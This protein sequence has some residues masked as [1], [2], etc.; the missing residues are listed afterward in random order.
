VRVFDG[1]DNK[2]NKTRERGVECEWNR[3]TD[4]NEKERSCTG[5]QRRRRRKSKRVVVFVLSHR[6]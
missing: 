4:S 5:I 2:K 3:E 6:L 1:I